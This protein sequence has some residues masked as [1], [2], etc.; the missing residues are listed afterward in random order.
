MLTLFKPWH[1]GRD[2]IT[3]EQ[4]WDD[5][6]V[7]HKFSSRQTELMKYFNLKYECLDARDDY[8]AQLKQGEGVGIFSVSDGD[9]EDNIEGVYHSQ[10]YGD[11]EFECEDDKIRIGRDIGQATNSTIN[12]RNEMHNIMRTSG[13]LIRV[14]MVHLS[15]EIWLQSNQK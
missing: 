1:D 3:D 14:Q 4:S 13:C 15:M 2:L 5:S 8:A 6:F 9:Y 12:L 10:G 7:N 11:G